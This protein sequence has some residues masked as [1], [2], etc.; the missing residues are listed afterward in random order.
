[1]SKDNRFEAFPG[2]EFLRYDEVLDFRQSLNAETD[3]GCALMAA[4]YLDAELEKLLR[5]YLVDNDSVQNEIL[6]QSGPLGP[7][8]TRIDM[9]YL[10]GLIG[11]KARRDLHLIRKIRNQ[12]G[13]RAT[14]L[15]FDE[16]ALASR[17]S[18]LYHDV[19]ENT[20]SPRRKFIRAALGVLGIIH[21]NLHSIEPLKEDADV[22]LD[23]AKV[24]L[25][26]LL[27]KLELNDDA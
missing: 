19:F 20:V 2:A 26:K 1:M 8:S 7:F 23:N 9:A 11:P 24:N 15:D 10:L 4:A 3:R 17:C 5:K 14:P 16:A 25:K 21:A 18:K 22:S 13:H 12:F 27:N 6:R